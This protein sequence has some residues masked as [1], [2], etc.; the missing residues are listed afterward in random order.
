MI[1]LYNVQKLTKITAFRRVMAVTWWRQFYQSTLRRSGYR[2]NGTGHE[3]KGRARARKKIFKPSTL[4]RDQSIFMGIRDREIC[5]GTT[6]YFGPLVERGHQLFWGLALRGHGLFQCRISTGPKI[7]LK[8]SGTGL[9]TIFS[10]VGSFLY[11]KYGT[12]ADLYYGTKNYFERRFQRGRGKI[13]TKRIRGHHT[14][15]CMVKSTGPR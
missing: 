14:L 15:F 13:L 5:N 11:K 12:R 9:W 7:I 6:G 3:N 1:R 10:F 8:Y 4:L 2:C